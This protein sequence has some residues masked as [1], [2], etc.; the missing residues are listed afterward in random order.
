M[1]LT[2]LISLRNVGP[3]GWVLVRMYT[4]LIRY[5]CKAISFYDAAFNIFTRF[6]NIAICYRWISMLFGQT[7]FKMVDEISQYIAILLNSN[8]DWWRGVNVSTWR[9][10]QMETFSALLA[11]FEGNS[12]VT[13]EFHSRR[14][15][16]RSCDVFFDLRLNK[17]LSNPTRRWWLETPSRS[18]WRHC[19]EELV[20]SSSNQIMTYRLSIT[21]LLSLPGN[22]FE[23][24]IC[25]ISAVLFRIQRVTWQP[26]FHIAGSTQQQRKHQSCAIL[27]AFWRKSTGHQRILLT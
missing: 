6:L 27:A 1:P 5:R 23:S 14:P 8:E 18:L 9:P 19:N 21:K 2:L 10:H 4:S 24:V 12:P 22:A 13:G 20:W 15:V 16:T 26:L 11:F 17:R 7:L 25:K 3:S